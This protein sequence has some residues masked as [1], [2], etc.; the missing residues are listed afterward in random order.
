MAEIVNLRQAR[1]RRQREERETQAAENRRRHGRTLEEKRSE[2]DQAARQARELD[3][4]LRD[5]T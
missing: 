5:R 4:H 3:G 2:A 1:K